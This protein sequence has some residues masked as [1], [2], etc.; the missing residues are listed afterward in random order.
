MK[1]L[2][3]SGTDTEVGKTWIACQILRELRR[4]GHRVG[5]WKPVCSGAVETNGRLVWEDLQELATAIG[6]EPDDAALIDRICR[7]RFVAPMAPNVAAR[8]EGR[9]V[10]DELP[11]AGVEAWRD[12]AEFLLVEG[13][14]GLLSPVSD[15]MLVADLAR[16]LRSPVLLVSANRLGTIHQTLS[17]VEAARTR[18]L[19]V[20]AVVLNQV[21]AD[22]DPTLLQTN[23]DELRRLMPRTPLIVTAR[24]GAFPFDA[25]AA[26]CETWF[27]PV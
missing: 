7:N 27:R 11:A 18:E 4:K 25:A 20:A 5:V 6:G 13:A 12:H 15:E 17:T 22:V 19:D 8:L 2:F 24:D 16:Q 10:S 26:D 3:V 14:G 1:T 9:I 23:E 21:S